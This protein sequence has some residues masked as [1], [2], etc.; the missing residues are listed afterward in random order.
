MQQVIAIVGPTASGKTALAIDLALELHTE[1]VSADSM[2][3]YRGMEIGTGQPTPEQLA[4]VNH[5]FIGH[6]A[7]AE[8]MSA[9]EYAAAAREVVTR[10]NSA[11]KPAVVVGG[12]GLYIRALIDG[13]FEGPG[14]S[15]DI[16]ARL[17]NRATAGEAHVLYAE[18]QRVDPEYAARIQPGDLR[19][20]VRA[21]EVFEL[22]GRPLSTLHAEQQAEAD[23]LDA[24][25]VA[26]DWPRDELYKRIDRRVVTMFDGGLLDEVQRLLDQGCEPQLQRLKTLAYREC[27]SYLRGEIPLD[28]TV[29]AIQQDTRRYAKRQLSWFRADERVRWIAP[30]R[31]ETPLLRVNDIAE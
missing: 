26:L 20:I 29:A 14:R 13:L 28:R 18:L 24:V 5:H 2:Q 16:R 27:I 17:H 9:G 11:G 31:G 3:F 22:T 23:P 10:I 4:L 30:V 6:L 7:P 21:L 25:Q 19:R 12:S 8:Y 1:I 15:C